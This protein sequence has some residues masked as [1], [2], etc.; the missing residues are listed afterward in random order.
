MAAY[1]P[2]ASER[3]AGRAHSRGMGVSPMQA[4]TFFTGE[5]PV[6]RC[7]RLAAHWLGHTVRPRVIPKATGPQD[8]R[9]P[10]AGQ[11]VRL[12]PVHAD[13]AVARIRAAGD[14]RRAGDAP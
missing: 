13:E 4:V 10:A 6:P 2:Q 5:T 14:H 8:R 12:A 9:P 1:A 3:K 7:R 11:A